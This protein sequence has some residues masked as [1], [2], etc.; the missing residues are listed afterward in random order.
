[1]EKN[2]I[3]VK[4]NYIWKKFQIK[5][6]LN[7]N[8]FLIFNT[9]SS[10]EEVVN[11]KDTRPINILNKNESIDNLIQLIHLHEPAILDVLT[12]RYNDNIIYTFTGP[13]LLA[14]NPFKKLN[15]Y[16]DEIILKY[17]KLKN[18]NL[19]PH[20]FSIAKLAYNNLIQNKKN[21][22]ILISGESGAGKTVTAKL[23]M[24]YLS[25]NN[26]KN[27]N[28]EELVLAANPIL[29]SFGNA[30]TIRNNNSSRFGKFI[31][32]YFDKDG[33]LSGAMIETYLLE[34]IRV[35]NQSKNERNFHIFYQLLKTRNIKKNYNFLNKNDN[36]NDIE[37]QDLLNK[38]MLKFNFS[39]EE[40]EQIY[41]AVIG[42]LELGNIEINQIDNKIDITNKNHLH[43]TAELLGIDTILLKKTILTKKIKIIN[44]V[45][46]SNLTKKEIINRINSLAITFYQNIFDYIVL[47][48]NNQISNFKSDTKIGILDIFGFEIFEKNNFEQLCI[49]YA[50]ESL[51]NQ[52]NKYI[53][54]Y[55]QEIYKKEEIDWTF[56]K[57]EDNQKFID[58]IENNN[59]GIISILNETCR[60]SKS[61]D[62]K[63][64]CQL[65]NNHQKNDKFICKSLDK[66]KNQFYLKHYAGTVKYNLNDFCKKNKDELHL[67]CVNLINSSKYLFLNSKKNNSNSK[68]G[69]I[70]TV[71][72]STQFKKQLLNLMRIIKKTTPHYIRCIK[73]NDKNIPD[74]INQQRTIEQ[75]HYNGV[76]EAVR[77]AR[78]GFPIRYNHCNFFNRYKILNNFD[79]INDIIDFYHFDKN[80]I[81][82]GLTKIFL[83]KK[84]FDLLELDRNKILD[85]NAIRIQNNVRMYLKKNIFKKILISTV[86]IQ[87]NYR[88][89]KSIQIYQYLKKIK[90]TIIIQTYYRHHSK[91]KKFNTTKKSIIRIQLF[92][93]RHRIKNKI[94]YKIK[95]KNVILIQSIIRSYLLYNKYI[96]YIKSIIFIQNL[97]R[98]RKS[99]NI[100]LILKKQANSIEKIK[101]DFNNL[102]IENEKL[103]IE[104]ENL[105]E[106]QNKIISQEHF[107][108]EMFIHYKNILKNKNEI[109]SSQNNN[110]KQEII[111]KL[112]T[113]L[114]ENEIL[115]KKNSK[116]E[117]KDNGSCIIC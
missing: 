55:E 18:I 29:E 75:L 88:R 42:I 96:K 117:I 100:F 48:I 77:V 108:Q 27:T 5:K 68:T 99:Y 32:I 34:K 51:Q 8:Q 90:S 9:I 17:Y 25:L 84:I 85:N 1:M 45:C 35:I 15:I 38:A 114:M 76:L 58:L 57:Y 56:I 11:I 19:K 26:N 98:K 59:N 103:K 74:Y 71:T 79:K 3:W 95:I 110:V 7:H 41:D 115:K 89:H 101:R 2:I 87:S 111:L 78:L 82:Y 70:K 10:K 24:K 109:I 20:I 28:I 39:S 73:P 94:N 113:V 106:Y 16:S 91:R 46:Y 52:F 36:T 116:L 92:F 4:N 49:N 62:T 67:D 44:E 61:T 23:I 102:K 12:N 69:S 93:I 37:M 6:V 60:F 112:N 54:K 22:S 63:F 64:L 104:N 14:I 31:Q 43:A 97:Y 81:Q 40:I 80:Q 47:R 33:Y 105:S 86:V 107:I 66:S 13:I 50:N 83:K 65:I 53:F 30:K 21:Q 72:V